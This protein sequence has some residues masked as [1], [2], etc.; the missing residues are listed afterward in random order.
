MIQGHVLL[1]RKEVF[2]SADLENDR[3]VLF[4]FPF[5]KEVVD[6]ACPNFGAVCLSAAVTSPAL[7]LTADRFS[8]AGADW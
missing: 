2:F 6:F 7:V 4:C 8:S 3:P 5:S 1:L